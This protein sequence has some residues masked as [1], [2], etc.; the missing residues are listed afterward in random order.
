MSSRPSIPHGAMTP[1]TN[2]LKAAAIYLRRST[3]RQEKSLEDQRRDIFRFAAEN[4]FGI[5]AEYVDD[6]VSGTS[7]ETR[8]G[9]LEMLAD[10]KSPAC[11]WK[12]ILTWDVKRFGRMSSDEAGHYRWILKQS[13][14]EV[15]YTSD[16]FTGT[17]ADKFLRFFKQEAARDESVTLSKAVIRGLV[18][19]SDEGWWTGGQAPY[20]YD[21]GYYDQTGSLFQIARATDEGEKLILDPEGQVIRKVPRGQKVKGSRAEHVRLIPG[22]SERVEVVRRVFAWYTGSSSLGFKAIADRLN[23]EGIPSPKG[24]GWALSSIR[25]LL[26]NEVYLGRIVFNRR[27]MG[28]FH[29]IANR[30]EVERDGCG[31]RRLEWNAREDWLIHENA[32]E[33]L[34]DAV[35]FER[36]R[37]IAKERADQSYAAGFLTGKAKVSPYLLSGLMTCGACGGSMHGRTTSKG[38]P[39]KDGSRVR[40]SYYVC[41][42]AITKGKAICLPIQFVQAGL[43]DFVMDLVGKRI[44]SFLGKN[45]RAIL[46]KLVER[47]LG[48]KSRDPRPEIR[49]LKAQLVT[50]ATKIDSVIDLAASSPDSKDLLNER[51]GRLRIQRQEI[52]GR[53][54]ELEVVPVGVSEPEAVVDAIL[55]GLADARQLFQH[56]T[57]EERKRVVRAF[58]EGLTVVG[59]SR[60]GELRMKKLPLP[61]Q[62]SNGSSFEMVAGVGFEPTTLPSLKNMRSYTTQ[63]R[64]INT[65]MERLTQLLSSGVRAGIFRL[66]FGLGPGELHVR[67]LAR[68]SG[69][70]EAS[71]RQEL[72]KLKQQ[73]LVSERRD[74]N[75][76]YY[77]ANRHHPLY[78]EIHQMVLKTSGLVEV[79]AQALRNQPLEVVFVFGSLADGSETAGSDVDLMVIGNLGLRKLTALLSGASEQVGREI[80]PHVMSNSEYRKRIHAG[81]HFVTGVLSGP[82]LFVLGT[83]DD[84]EGLG[85]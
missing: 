82:K 7:G 65:H 55:E 73:D 6:G 80:N 36:A 81:D 27:S 43:D 74:G 56:G 38:K 19:L 26:R 85:K 2:G 78:R 44:A 23:Q 76:V 54:S 68:Q 79:L 37:R 9:F 75:R 30:R 40:T 72:R 32:H 70:H 10:A 11:P 34:V 31:K 42:A 12:H 13:G 8:K 39:R 14:V 69:F 60:S 5:V 18:S 61:Q 53:L 63:S 41:G 33:P 1:S 4:G 51:L 46:K 59:S 64:G 49:R 16:G 25:T 83:Q 58:V 15:I 57:M 84:L 45:G 22:L 20:G 21:L 24:R 28:K 52:Q 66:L 62:L 17:S 50:M 3:D 47:E 35:T 29:R 48:A 77:Q 67:E 71:V